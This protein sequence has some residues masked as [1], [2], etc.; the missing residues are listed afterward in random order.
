MAWR[1]LASSWLGILLLLAC[2]GAGA[3]TAPLRL[4][5]TVS[6]VS[7]SPHV[8]YYHD[9]SG[10]EDVGVADQRLQQGKFQPL[11]AGNPSFGFQGGAYWFHVRVINSDGNE[12]RW[13]L[14]QQYALSDRIDVYA[15]QAGGPRRHAATASPSTSAASVTGT[16]ISG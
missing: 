1:R 7:L 15:Q 10:N 13:L 4:D 3:V 5:A 9:R 16:R 8:S 14:V 2:G 12:P 11:P 6:Q